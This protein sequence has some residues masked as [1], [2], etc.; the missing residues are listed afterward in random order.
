MMAMGGAN[1]AWPTS[2]TAGDCNCVL[3]GGVFMQGGGTDSEG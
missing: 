2:S 1:E 3:A